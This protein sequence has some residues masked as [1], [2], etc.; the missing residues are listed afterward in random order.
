MYFP[1]NSFSFPNTPSFPTPYV[2]GTV[3]HPKNGCEMKDIL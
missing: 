3:L 2:A 1:N